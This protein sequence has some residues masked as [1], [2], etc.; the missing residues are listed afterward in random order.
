MTLAALPA[1]ASAPGTAAQSPTAQ[2]LPQTQ[3]RAKSGKGT[4]R[5]RIKGVPAGRSARLL[6]TNWRHRHKVVVRKRSAVKRLA[7]GRYTISALPVTVRRNTYDAKPQKVRIT[8][9]HASTA[10]VRF[11][12]VA[13]V[14]RGTEV[15]TADESRRMIAV[16]PDTVVFAG[17]SSPVN[18]GEILVSAPAPNAPQGLLR[19]VTGVSPTPQG[20]VAQTVPASLTDALVEASV[21]TRNL[22]L[23]PT[24]PTFVD[25]TG[26]SGPSGITP[27]RQTQAGASVPVTLTRDWSDSKGP[28]SVSASVTIELEQSVDV[29]LKISRR[30]MRGTLESF[31]TKVKSKRAIKGTLSA[32]GTVEMS[33]S[34]DLPSVRVGSVVI[35]AGP[36]PIVFTFRLDPKLKAKVGFQRKASASLGAEAT[37]E[38]ELFYR[39]R[40]WGASLSSR[41]SVSGDLSTG[42][43]QGYAEA[44]GQLDLAVSLYDQAGPFIG[45]EGR[46]RAEATPEANDLSRGRWELKGIV[47]GN[48]G[49]KV[50]PLG[51]GSTDLT[52]PLA[53]KTLPIK[54]GTWGPKEVVTPPGFPDMKGKIGVDKEGASFYIDL[55]GGRHWIPDGGTFECLTAQGKQVVRN[56]DGAKLRQYPGYEDAA[57][58]RADSGNV[59]KHSDGD[60]YLYEGGKLRHIT[61]GET[62]TCLVDGQQRRVVGAPRYWILDT[63]HGSD[64]TTSCFDPASARGKVVRSP[65]G[66]AYYVDL[67]G[68]RHWIPD[69]GTYQCLTAQGK[70]LVD[71]VPQFYLDRMKQYENAEC[72]RAQPGNVIRHKDGDAYVLNA[73]WTRSWIPTGTSYVCNLASRTLVNNVPRYYIDD[74]TRTGDSTF[75]TG[76]CI[77]RK[78][79]GAAFFVNNQG[80]REWF[81][82]TPTWDCEVGRGVQVVNS[83]D[84]Y[85]D[86]IGEAGWHYCLNKANLR[87]KVLRHNDGDAHYIHPD[88][89]RTWIPD[90]FTYNCRTAAG[91]PVVGTMWRQYVD[92]FTSKGWDYC[93]NVNTFKNRHIVHPEGDRHFVG[94]DGRRHWIPGS[95]ADCMVARYGA[96][97][98]VRWREYIDNMAEG[99]WAVCGDTL[100]RNQLM[101]R[102]QWLRSANGRYTLH[103]QTDGNLVLY[104]AGGAAIWATHRYGRHLKL[105]DDGCLAEVDNGGNWLW[106]TGCNQGGDR[107]V[108]QSDG[109]LVLY[110]GSRAVWASN[111]AGR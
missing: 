88:D 80:K 56:L 102:G 21:S 7:P 47:G 29:D 18:P 43:W 92:A 40:V 108:V 14:T 59:V 96:P 90:E 106:Q 68:G 10:R 51:M 32:S 101:D 26:T 95:R 69:G 41:W 99:E 4:L 39:N 36:V 78:P 23:S 30:G 28:A 61:N 66:T 94:G 91:T 34:Q 55:R 57:C 53:E 104:N 81:P 64:L 48:I 27:Q 46:L 8:K 93:F 42:Q 19:R 75:P 44:G 24:S 105:H 45:L 54:E 79:G 82:D 74:L 62:Y 13:R 15:L 52:I 73:N 6:I 89:T 31:S 16:T 85:V 20:V 87:G 98:T 109:N 33:T 63:P 1:E 50:T 84:A 11:R 3:T 110:A 58:V 67:R 37:D 65:Q 111:T 103:M 76:N 100:Y 71:R 5:I 77:V 38:T 49:G 22:P 72:V 25:A 97:A 35:M 12:K 70:P 17:G 83:S 60:S 86:S 9:G 107:L 2:S